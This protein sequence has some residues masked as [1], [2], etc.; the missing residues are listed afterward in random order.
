MNKEELKE[1]QHKQYMAHREKRLAYANAYYTEHKEHVL[2]RSAKSYAEN[3]EKFVLKNK[4]YRAT[5]TAK[6][7]QRRHMKHW[8][9]TNTEKARAQR[10]VNAQVSCGNF[11]SA[12]TMVCDI[13]QEALAAHWH[14]HNGYG[15]GH[16]IDVIAVCRP[17]HYETHRKL[18][19]RHN[20]PKEEASE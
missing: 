17:C 12:K 8:Y 6:K 19:N 10:R 5:A 16:E 13:C 2:E 4:A 7:N 3:R 1:Y 11:P 9:D 18:E 14:H 20:P 15:P